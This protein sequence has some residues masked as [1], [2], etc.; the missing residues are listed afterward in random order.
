M[1]NYCCCKHYDGS[2][3]CEERY[4]SLIDLPD[5]SPLIDTLSTYLPNGFVCRVGWSVHDAPNER[6]PLYYRPDLP[7]ATILERSLPGQYDRSVRHLAVS[8]SGHYARCRRRGDSTRLGFDLVMMGRLVSITAL[9]P[10]T[11]HCFALRSTPSLG[12]SVKS[13]K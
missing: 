7:D 8:A 3:R 5:C 10:P 4:Q 2:N 13:V 6:C 12:P 11:M 1:C 9:V